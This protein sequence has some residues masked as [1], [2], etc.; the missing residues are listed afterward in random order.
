MERVSGAWVATVKPHGWVHAALEMGGTRLST[1][2]VN[3]YPH[4]KIAQIKKILQ[5]IHF[6]KD[7]LEYR[8]FLKG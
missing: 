7:F 3:K 8:I 5:K 1:N 4:W 6:S 2:E